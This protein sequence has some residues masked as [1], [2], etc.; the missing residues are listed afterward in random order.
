LIE[1]LA[2]A[3]LEIRKGVD[4]AIVE[5][6]RQLERLLNAKTEYQAL[7]FNGAHTDEQ[8]AEVAN[9]IKSLTAQY[10]DVEAEIRAKSPRYAALTRPQTLN[11]QE[12]QRQTLDD[13][14]LLLEYFLGAEH[15]YL[16]AV[17]ANSV[18]SY[19]L[20]KR[21]DIEEAAIR[22]KKLLTA[23]GAREEGESPRRRQA[24][25]AEAEAKYW[26][27]AARLSRMILGPAVSEI[28]GKRL[29]I[30]PDGELQDVAFGAL[31]SPATSGADKVNGGPHQ[32][33]DRPPLIVE[34][35][36]VSLPSASA[37]A[38]LRK[39]TAGLRPAA[40]SVAVLADPV[41]DK[42]DERIRPAIAGGQERKAD[43]RIRLWPAAT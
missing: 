33:D 12:I 20:P 24:R 13:Q 37:L 43:R 1:R 10:Q 2:E 35:E 32:G 7:L 22:V 17:S 21:A 41:F 19:E 30:V 39:E 42:D 5:R 28:G 14:T 36:I 25:I 34:H 4:P 6:E 31:P 8:V 11:S 18:K 23:R 3:R 15:S 38:V 26:P 9:E 27:E 16:W 40:R 29:A